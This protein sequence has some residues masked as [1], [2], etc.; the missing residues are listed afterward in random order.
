M[1]VA[2]IGAGGFVGARVT[3]VLRACP[4]VKHI[5]AVDRAGMPASAKTSVFE[6]DFSDPGLRGAALAE[7][8]AVIFLA[9]ILGGAAEADYALAR[10]INVDATLD[11][12]EYLRDTAPQ[13]R[14]VNAS[15]V[16]VYGAPLPD[17][18]TDD[19]PLA[20]QM[21][22]GAQKA[23]IEVLL[24]NLARR[25]DLDAVSLRPAGVMARAGVDIAL[26]T[27]FMSRLFYSIRDSKD[28]TLPVAENSTSWMASVETV[29]SNFVEAAMRPDLGPTRA[30]TLPALQVRFGDLVASLRRRF[31]DSTATARFTPDPEII[32]LFGRHPKL[33]TQAADD[34]DLSRDRDADAL[35]E[36]AF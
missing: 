16:A 1:K 25:G 7:V 26:K 13:T 21:T 20:P 29:A 35:V 9:A 31:P 11:L 5:H 19:T 3:E 17:V 4:D 15:T 30:F 24:S 14:F 33:V 10:R 34:L 8:D 2:V 6:G 23:M 36:K 28:I 22:Y 27:S 12:V 32:A 18:V